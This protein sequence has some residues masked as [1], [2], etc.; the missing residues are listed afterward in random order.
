MILVATPETAIFALQLQFA[1]AAVIAPLLLALRATAVQ[2]AAAAT[3]AALALL[4][5]SKSVAAIITLTAKR[6]KRDGVPMSQATT[7]LLV[8]TR[9]L[10][11]V[12]VA[13]PSLVL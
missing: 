5:V 6:T 1:G 13:G 4:A 2:T 9:A 3:I 10:L 11:P 12:V 8:R 7:E